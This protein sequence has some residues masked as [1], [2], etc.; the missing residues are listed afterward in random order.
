MTESVTRISLEELTTIRMTCK[1]CG[2]AT[3]AKLSKAYKSMQDENCRECDAPMSG[4][5]RKQSLIKLNSAIEEL[6]SFK[7]ANLQFVIPQEEE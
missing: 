7:D 3:E 4:P 5:S 2:L 1:N 6:L